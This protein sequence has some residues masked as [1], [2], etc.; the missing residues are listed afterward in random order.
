[1]PA[2]WVCICQLGFA[3]P[4]FACMHD[5]HSNDSHSTRSVVNHVA[6]L[7]HQQQLCNDHK[8]ASAPVELYKHLP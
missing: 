6:E 7:P 3:L 8:G 4:A 1:M 2:W 5:S